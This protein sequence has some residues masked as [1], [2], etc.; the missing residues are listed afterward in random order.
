MKRL[1]PGPL[2]SAAFITIYLTGCATNYIKTSGEMNP[3]PKAKFSEF[4]QFEMRKLTISP[5][6]ADH[7]ANKKAAAKIQELL[8]LRMDSLL[9]TWN[10]KS[11][12]SAGQTLVIEPEVTQIKFIGGAARFWAGALAGSSAVTMK[13]TYKDQSS[14][15]T[16]AEP[17]FY[18]HAN[19]IGGAYSFGGTDNSMLNRIANLVMNYTNANYD[20]AV[21]GPTGTP[22]SK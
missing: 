13:V 9:E 18:Q 10:Q 15:E 21:G 12:G 2:L 5:E 11:A 14:G 8:H 6:Y 19:A 16:I 22:A 17:N 20:E 4:Q 7:P 3:P 1:R